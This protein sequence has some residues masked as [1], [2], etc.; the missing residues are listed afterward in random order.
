MFH[1]VPELRLRHSIQFI[2]MFYIIT[3]LAAIA[4]VIVLRFIY[5]KTKSLMFI[6]SFEL[7]DGILY[8]DKLPYDET[9]RISEAGGVRAYFDFSKGDLS[10]ISLYM[11]DGANANW[12]VGDKYITCYD[13]EGKYLSQGSFEALYSRFVDVDS[14]LAI[15]NRNFK[16]CQLS[17]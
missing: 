13:R 6:N 15:F 9:I 2:N 10:R 17:I 1:Q 7:V 16:K 5:N 8:K 11:K 14:I 12:R 4:T 3:I